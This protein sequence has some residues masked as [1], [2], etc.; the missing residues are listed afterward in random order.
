M[1]LVF[2]KKIEIKIDW[3]RLTGK[4][5]SLMAHRI[6]IQSLYDILCVYVVPFFL[7]VREEKFEI[8]CK[9]IKLNF[10]SS[11]Y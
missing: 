8:Y 3:G 6:P 7:F 2:S 10:F 9:K 5:N 11:H 1:L 4:S